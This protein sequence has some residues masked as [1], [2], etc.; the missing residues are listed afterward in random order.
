MT[1]YQFHSSDCPVWHPD[2]FDANVASRCWCQRYSNLVDWNVSLGN[3]SPAETDGLKKDL[4]DEKNREI[5]PPALQTDA[6]LCSSLWS[7]EELKDQGVNLDL[8]W[9]KLDE[10]TGSVET[11][12]SSSNNNATNTST[13]ADVNDCKMTLPFPSSE[14]SPYLSPAVSRSPLDVEALVS[15]PDGDLSSA[16]PLALDTLLFENNDD[17]NSSSGSG[18]PPP[19]VEKKTPKRRGRPP[20]RTNKETKS[21]RKRMPSFTDSVSSDSFDPSGFVITPDDLKPVPITK[22]SKKKLTPEEA[23]DD[24]YWARRKKNNMAAKRS[25]DIRRI[26]ENQI[27]IHASFLE[28]QVNSKM[29]AELEELRAENETLR[30]KLEAYEMSGL[31]R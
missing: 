27:A 12:S 22:K 20:G 4:F 24:K 18:E 10:V 31:K 26:K 21:P 8:L 17:N 11:S 3:L 19:T 25:R 16:S 14:S 30:R 1:D 2:K 9:K 28:T 29:K 6:F 5:K 13:S 7:T 15:L 23:K